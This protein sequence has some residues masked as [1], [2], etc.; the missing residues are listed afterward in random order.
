MKQ[1]VKL[2]NI[3]PSKSLGPEFDQQIASATTNSVKYKLDFKKKDKIAVSH[4]GRVP[5]ELRDRLTAMSVK[6][7]QF[8]DSY[9]PA[10]FGTWNRTT[11]TVNGKTPFSKDPVFVDYENDSDDE[12]EE[13]EEGD[14]CL[15]DEEDE[16]SDLEE[17]EVRCLLTMKLLIISD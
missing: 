8:H 6:L 5:I 13:E 15:S 12:W 16:E 1:N 7:L 4:H 14:E 9:R 2:G 17:E 11:T 3:H 10:F